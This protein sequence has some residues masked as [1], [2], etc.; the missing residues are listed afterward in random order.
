MGQPRTIQELTRLVH[1]YCP[2]IVLLLE[3]RQHK[4]CVSNL[5]YRIGFKH[6]FVVDGVVKLVALVCS[7]MKQ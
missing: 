6:F 2:N 4:D 1:E 7:G 5:R 3:T